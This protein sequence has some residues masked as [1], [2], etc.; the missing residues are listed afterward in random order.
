MKGMKD[1]AIRG[2]AGPWI[3]TIRPEDLELLRNWRNANLS[4]FYDT[5]PVS[6]GGQQKW[7]ENYLLRPQDYLFLVIDG[8]DAIGCL[9]IRLRKDAWEL[10]NVIRGR[11]SA[12]SAG[13]MSQALDLIREF[14]GRINNLPIRA[15]VLCDNPA[16]HWYQKNGFSIVARNDQAVFLISHGGRK[17]PQGSL[18]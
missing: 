1:H 5:M 13:C 2:N 6:G 18:S 10:Y 11:A 7:F 14:A 17:L 8:I 16:L 9:G 15:E 3:R 4:R 12:S